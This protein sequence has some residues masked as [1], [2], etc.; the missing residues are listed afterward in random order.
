M[1]ESVLLGRIGRQTASVYPSKMAG[2]VPNKCTH[3]RKRV[4]PSGPEECGVFHKQLWIFKVFVHWCPHCQQLMPLLY[5]L[6]LVLRQRGVN[7]LRFGAVNCATEHELCAT[8]NW[9]GHPLLVARY[10]GP[11][12]AV[13]DAIEHWVDVVKDAQ[14]RQML[15]RY[16]LPGEFPVL[17]LLLEQLPSSV[18]SKSSWSSLFDAEGEHSQASGCANLTALHPEFPEATSD[19]VGNGWHDAEHNF[20]TRQRWTDALLMLRHVLQ[21]WIAPIGD[22]GNA[23]AFSHQQLLV[24][25]PWIELLARNIPAAFG[26][27]ETL[28]ALHGALLQRVRASQ[29]EAGSSLCADE[30][31]SLTTPVLTQIA[32]VGQRDFAVPSACA[33][34]TCRMWSLLHTLASEGLRLEQLP[35]K[36]PLTLSP[37]APDV[38]LSLL[39]WPGI[40][41]CR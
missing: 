35:R 39:S 6:A 25:E 3:H 40:S 24:M 28:Q 16:A 19:Q 17:K 8:Q 9:P 33:S 31:K 27:A 2:W 34:D 11:N 18:L 12:R 21:E 1:V 15:P 22:D 36:S 26:L 29:T 13:H 5:R 4:M 7:T 14:L 20:T 37:S 38:L 41:S 32:Q 23:D 10:L 30:W